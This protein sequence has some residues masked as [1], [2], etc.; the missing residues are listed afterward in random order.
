VR[1]LRHWLGGRRVKVKT[2]I[3]DCVGTDE[4]THKL[5]QGA[6]GSDPPSTMIL[7]YSSARLTALQA[8]NDADL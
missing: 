8:S 1:A 4:K 6:P 7:I 2:L 3:P 5:A